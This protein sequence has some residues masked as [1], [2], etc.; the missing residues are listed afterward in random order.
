MQN[1]SEPK[2]RTVDPETG[3]PS[4]AANAIPYST[5]DSRKKVDPETGKPSTASNAIPN[6]TFKKR[7]QNSASTSV[8]P[9]LPEASATSALAS[10]L[11]LKTNSASAKRKHA[12]PD[13][14][15]TDSEIEDDER[16]NTLAT[17]KK[18]MTSHSSSQINNSFSFF[19]QGVVDPF[20][21]LVNVA[22]VKLEPR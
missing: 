1:R 10:Q 20:K 5:F 18:Q 3:K 2:K 22:T 8:S 4:T 12:D 6:S 17:R 7:K 19:Q 15:E 14:T 13:E 9:T 11:S 21:Q 16:I